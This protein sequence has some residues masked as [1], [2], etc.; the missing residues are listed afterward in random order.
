M[1]ERY[2]LEVDS[3][4]GAFTVEAIVDDEGDVEVIFSRGG[5][6]KFRTGATELAVALTF[7]EKHAEL[8]FVEPSE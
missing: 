4:A 7:I 2:E 8:Q 1:S 3:A 6:P 5:A